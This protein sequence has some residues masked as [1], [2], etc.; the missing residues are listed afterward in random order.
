[1]TSTITSLQREIKI[2]LLQ[3]SQYNFTKLEND[4][5]IYGESLPE[6]M[7]RFSFLRKK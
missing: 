2:F 4:K 5:Q 3:I 7:I 1:M 6:K